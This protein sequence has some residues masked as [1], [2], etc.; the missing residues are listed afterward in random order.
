MST[1]SCYSLAAD[2]RIGEESGSWIFDMDIRLIVYQV[3]DSA[4]VTLI[5]CPENCGP[6]VGTFYVDVVLACN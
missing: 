3:R 2:M 5:A 4:G 6:V 1:N